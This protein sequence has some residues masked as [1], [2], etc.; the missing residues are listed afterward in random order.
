MRAGVLDEFKLK[1]ALVEQKR[2]NERLGKILVDMNFISEGILVKALSKQLGIPRATFSNMNVSQEIVGKVDVEFARAHGLCP[3]HY[4]SERKV[5]TVAMADPG[6]MRAID[7]L[8]FK[9]GMKI[10]TTIAGERQIATAITRF[11]AGGF[12]ED[13]LELGRSGPRFHATQPQFSEARLSSSPDDGRGQTGAPRSRAAPPPP[14]GV[15]RSVGQQAR[16]MTPSQPPV[17][18]VGGA[19]KADATVSS[20]ASSQAIEMAQALDGAQRQQ[21]KAIRVM[22]DLLVEKGIFSQDEFL[23]LLNKR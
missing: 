18:H 6:N 20:A 13:S 8:R 4:D 3:E 15:A 21:S 16:P 22:V 7:E 2:W 9:T 11:L 14:P 12:S 10:K 1:A 5:L 17:P 19:A 23:A